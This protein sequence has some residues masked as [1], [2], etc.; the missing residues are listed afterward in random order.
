MTTEVNVNL[1]K[2]HGCHGRGWVETQKGAQL[3]PVCNGK[4]YLD[5]KERELVVKW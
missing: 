4:G 2:C 5:G 3:C 1:Q